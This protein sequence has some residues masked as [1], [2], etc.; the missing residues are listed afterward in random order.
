MWMSLQMAIGGRKAENIFHYQHIDFLSEEWSSYS[1]PPAN[2]TLKHLKSVLNLRTLFLGTK[3]IQWIFIIQVVYAFQISEDLNKLPLR[4]SQNMG[5]S[6][7]GGTLLGKICKTPTF[8]WDTPYLKFI[9]SLPNLNC[10]WRIY[11]GIEEKLFHKNICILKEVINVTK[12]Y[13][14]M[15]VYH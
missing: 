8:D 12:V 3:I 13:H 5:V 10:G 1:H 6:L 14:W 4:N 15:V 7:D 11:V 9:Q 2:D